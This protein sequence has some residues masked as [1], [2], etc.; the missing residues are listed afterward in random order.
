MLKADCP[1]PNIECRFGLKADYMTMSKVSGFW[2][3]VT[4]GIILAYFPE[5]HKVSQ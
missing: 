3:L 2:P 4:A 5:I 1:D